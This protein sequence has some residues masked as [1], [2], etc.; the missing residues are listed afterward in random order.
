MPKIDDG[1]TMVST[2]KPE[3][4]DQWSGTAIT[5]RVALPA[6]S[7]DYLKESTG[8]GAA[9]VNA[10]AKLLAGR[11]LEWTRAD[12]NGN[13]IPLTDEA[14]RQ[15]PYPLLS[16]M[17]ESVMGYTLNESVNDAKNSPGPS[18]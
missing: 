11:L 3:K 14:V 18:A 15:T 1:Y 10:A 9:H 17:V 6:A 4:P 2:Y 8:S 7:Y 12:L 5:Y 13:P 16:W